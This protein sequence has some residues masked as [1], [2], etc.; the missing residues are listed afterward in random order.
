M[1]FGVSKKLIASAFLLFFLSVNSY[2]QKT[3]FGMDEKMKSSG[4][5]TV[6]VWNILKKYALEF[7][8]GKPQKKWFQIAKINLN[9]DRR[10]DLIAYPVENCIQGNNI[11]NFFVFRGLGNNKFSLVL[12]VGGNSLSI[13]KKMKN[14]FNQ[15]EVNSFVGQKILTRR[16]LFRKKSYSLSSESYTD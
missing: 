3:T 15:I 11:T 9:N 14:S 7:N 12:K 10:Y 13:L 1:N 6:A 16:F 2:S 5:P 4:A 8:C